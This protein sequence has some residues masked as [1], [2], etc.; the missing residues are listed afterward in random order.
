M[1]ARGWS[2]KVVSSSE[3]TKQ[4]YDYHMTLPEKEQT[5]NVNELVFQNQKPIEEVKKAE[6]KEEALSSLS[7]LDRRLRSESAINKL[8]FIDSMDWM[9]QDNITHKSD[10]QFYRESN[11]PVSELQQLNGKIKESGYKEGQGMRVTFYESLHKITNLVNQLL[12]SIPKEHF[13]FTISPC[14]YQGDFEKKGAQKIDLYLNIEDLKSYGP[15]VNFQIKKDLA[16]YI[17]LKSENRE[18]LKQFCARNR[19]NGEWVLSAGRLMV[20]FA[21]IIDTKIRPLFEKDSD[22]KRKDIVFDAQLKFKT[23]SES[24]VRINIAFPEKPETVYNIGLLLAFNVNDFPNVIDMN[25]NRQW[26]SMEG[27]AKF[28][29]GGTHLIAVPGQVRNHAWAV[30]FLKTRKILLNFCDGHQSATNILLALQVINKTALSNRNCESLLLPVHFIMI[31]FWVHEAYRDPN[32]WIQEKMSQRFIDVLMALKRC[33]EKK[34]CP[35]FFFPKSNYFDGLPQE[36]L[37]HLLQNVD[38]VLA[39]PAKYLS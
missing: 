16:A 22:K 17:L 26:P 33:L 13:P 2:G 1:L 11:H 21:Y 7:S 32:D 19:D 15:Q 3:E 4:K 25:K 37:H 9:I 28:I 8:L 39:E 23:V 5:N 20:L 34:L 12:E 10:P 27:K 29:Q 6:K 24:E 14:S 35:D 30:S 38:E 18:K 36:K 31:L